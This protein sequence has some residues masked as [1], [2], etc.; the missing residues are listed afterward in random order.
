MLILISSLSRDFFIPLNETA[1][2]LLVSFLS[3]QSHAFLSGKCF[4]I[5]RRSL[6]RWSGTEGSDFY[7]RTYLIHCS[8]RRRS[9]K[10]PI[11]FFR[12]STSSWT[13]NYSLFLLIIRRHMSINTTGTRRQSFI[14]LI[15]F[16]RPNFQFVVQMKHFTF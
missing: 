10:Y 3:V 16:Q 13:I 12:L 1:S 6:S 4:L 7:V 11:S 14:F 9:G 8:V 2:T 15:S 5:K